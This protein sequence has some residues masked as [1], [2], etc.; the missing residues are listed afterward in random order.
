MS[1]VIFPTER[2]ALILNSFPP[3]VVDFRCLLSFKRTITNVH[4]NLLTR[5]WCFML[6]FNSHCS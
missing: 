6:S 1:D 2:I 3:S 5:Y 4:V